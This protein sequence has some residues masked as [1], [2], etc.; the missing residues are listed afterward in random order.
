MIWLGS[1]CTILSVTLPD[2]VPALLAD[3]LGLQAFKCLPTLFMAVLVRNLGSNAFERRKHF[4]DAKES[5]DSLKS[6][7]MPRG[8]LSSLKTF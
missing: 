6:Q 2:T 3:H 1:R 7:K 5:E 8:S 4:E